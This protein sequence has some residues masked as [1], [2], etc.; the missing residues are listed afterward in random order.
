MKQ[1]DIDEIKK[2]QL[3]ILDYVHKFC[4]ENDIHY[5][6]CGGTLIGAVRH[7]GYIPW[8]D[9]ID[10]MMP[11]PDYEKFCSI[12]NLTCENLNLKVL[13]CFNDKQYFQPF[14]KVVDT[15]TKLMEFYDRPV[16][17]LG[18]YI[19]VFPADFLPDNSVDRE[20]YWKRIFKRRNFATIIYQKKNRKEGCIKSFLR[21][22]LF[23]LFYPLP[24]NVF[25]KLV[26][27]FAVKRNL[28]SDY[29]ACSV[30][31]YGEKEEMP[32]SVFDYFVELDFEGKK[33]NAMY[34]YKTY[35]T[36][37][38]GDYMELPSIEKQIPKHD[39]KAFW[40]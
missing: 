39:F 7:K 35:L 36:N 21:I 30:F 28:P 33:Y 27:N 32:K 1:L 31:G 13:T 5:S 40:R 6:L 26:N 24:A 4:V 19:D 11:R 25:A 23:Y 37:I 20:K 22:L 10:I 34:D 17:N 29:M 16:D 14:A 2:I 18:V 12:F 3:S 15:R 8:D 38:Y 9:D